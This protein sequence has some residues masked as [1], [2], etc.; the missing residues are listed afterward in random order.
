MLG[1]PDRCDKPK[2]LRGRGLSEILCNIGHRAGIKQYD[3][4]SGEREWLIPENDGGNNICHYKA[5][6]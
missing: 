6:S 4:S 1:E 3:T 2:W 5:N